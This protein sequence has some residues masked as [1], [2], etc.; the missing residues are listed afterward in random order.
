MISPV[1]SRDCVDVDHERRLADLGIIVET[2][3]VGEIT[4]AELHGPRFNDNIIMKLGQCSDIPTIKLFGTG[5]TPQGIARLKE[6]LP[7][8][9]IESGD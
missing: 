2:N 8:T 4:V 5:F 1:P 6:L 7:R 3:D 9:S